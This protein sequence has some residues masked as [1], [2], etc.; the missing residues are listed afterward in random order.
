M[1][2]NQKLLNELPVLIL[3][4]S[5]ALMSGDNGI[6]PHRRPELH[7]LN[8]IDTIRWPC[9]KTPCLSS[10]NAGANFVVECDVTDVDIDS[11]WRNGDSSEA[12]W[13]RGDVVK[14]VVFIGNERADEGGKWENGGNALTSLCAAKKTSIKGKK[15]FYGV[16]FNLAMKSLRSDFL[17]SALNGNCM[18]RGVE[19]FCWLDNGGCCV[20]SNICVAML[21]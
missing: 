5:S 21:K 7:D 9:G 15:L 19:R 20:T 2:S 14:R 4:D 8:Q 13:A 10:H 11:W 6:S 18:Q 1:V 3:T 16:W 17:Q 12:R